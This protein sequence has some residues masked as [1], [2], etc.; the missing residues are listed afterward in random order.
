MDPSFKYFL[1]PAFN[2]EMFD[3]ACIHVFDSIDQVAHSVIFYCLFFC[4]ILTVAQYG[5]EISLLPSMEQLC[6]VVSLKGL[7]EFVAEVVD[8]CVSFIDARP[9][10]DIVV[11]LH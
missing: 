5:Y 8:H 7:E 1:L 11:P 6:V 4:D 2:N 3:V 10:L 9:F